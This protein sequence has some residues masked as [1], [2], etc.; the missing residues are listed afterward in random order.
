M[1]QATLTE[2]RFFEWHEDNIAVTLRNHSGSYGGGSEVLIICFNICFNENSKEGCA[3]RLANEM[4][5][6]GQEL[7]SMVS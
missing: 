2:K 3:Q 4:D 5:E 6:N 1:K 7:S